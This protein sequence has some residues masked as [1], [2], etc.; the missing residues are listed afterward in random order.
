[1]APASRFFW[2]I[3]KG[4]LD[5]QEDP[6]IAARRE[7]AEE[8]G[9]EARGPLQPLGEV[10]QRAG[11]I[12]HGYALE[13]DLD[14]DG[15]RSNEVSIEWPPRSGRTMSFPEIDRAACSPSRWP[16]RK[17]WRA[18]GRF[19]IALKCSRTGRRR[20]RDLQNDRYPVFAHSSSSGDLNAMPDIGSNK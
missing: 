3:P 9:T 12:V 2:S 16:G 4:E 8:L 10:R 19:S 13:G 1:V 20:R 6:E 17:S 18:S 5:D 11:K 14:A 7:F 15:I